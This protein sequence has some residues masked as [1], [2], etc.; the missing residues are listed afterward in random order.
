ML[1]LYS[2]HMATSRIQLTDALKSIFREIAQQL[3]DGECRRIASS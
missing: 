3:R 2:R 1:F